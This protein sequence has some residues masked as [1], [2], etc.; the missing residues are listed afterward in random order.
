MTE[1][2]RKVLLLGDGAVGKTSL[3]RRFVTSAFSDDYIASI[4]TKVTKKQLA[5]ERVDGA[6]EVTLMIWDVLGQQE[7]TRIQEGAFAN[8]AAA[9][10]VYDVSRVETYESLKKFWIRRLWSVAG[11]VPVVVLANKCDL[12]EHRPPELSRLLRLTESLQVPGWLVSAKTGENV[13]VAFSAL[14]G[15]TLR[16]GGAEDPAKVQVQ[17]GTGVNPYAPAAVADKIM[18]D[19]CNGSGGLEAGMPIAVVSNPPAPVSGTESTSAP[20]DSAG[21]IDSWK[22]RHLWIGPAWV[23][24]PGCPSVPQRENAVC[25]S[26][27][28]Q[29]ARAVGEN[30]SNACST[31]SASRTGGREMIAIIRPLHP[32]PH[33]ACKPL[34]SVTNS[35]SPQKSFPRP[36]RARIKFENRPFVCEA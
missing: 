3:I 24:K 32:S 13:E 10:L 35:L 18:M 17:L 19:F 1:V 36:E 22:C 14:A 11:K 9:L 26:R 8:A 31:I 28:E 12:L 21:W 16:D 27:F 30:K 15:M 34:Y 25:C 7:Y 4:G 6:A 23:T 33:L 2:K 20:S 5:L 29:P